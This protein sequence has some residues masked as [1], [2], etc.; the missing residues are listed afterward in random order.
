MT[1][2]AAIWHLL[3]ADAILAV[4]D[5]PPLTTGAQARPP[6]VPAEP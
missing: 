6:P 3:T 2:R 4:I 5:V 1:R